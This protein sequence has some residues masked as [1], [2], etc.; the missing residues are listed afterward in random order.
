MT[1]L[2]ARELLEI[3]GSGIAFWIAYIP[4]YLLGVLDPI[5]DAG[6]IVCGWL[7][8]G[9]FGLAVELVIAG[10]TEM[11]E[12]VEKIV[13]P[14]MYVTLPLTGM[15]FMISWLPYRMAKVVS[16]SPTANCFELFRAGL[17]GHNVTAT[18]DAAYTVK[19]CLVL[20]AIG[21]YSVRKARRHI[22]ID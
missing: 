15:F 11:H 5:Y 8:L 14:L 12:L 18:W 22:R 1:S 6:Q 7:L 10:L 19:C 20:T 3:A 17:L 16:Y 4:L 21:L 2:I 13:Q 9:W